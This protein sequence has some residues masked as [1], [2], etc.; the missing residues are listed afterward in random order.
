MNTEGEEEGNLPML[1]QIEFTPDN[2]IFL[3]QMLPL[4]MS[5][6]ISDLAVNSGTDMVYAVDYDSNSVSI[7][8]LMFNR[9]IHRLEV[10]V[11]S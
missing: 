6:T 10:G 4:N 11:I 8:D 1:T 3:D 5:Y 2:A 7:I 9:T